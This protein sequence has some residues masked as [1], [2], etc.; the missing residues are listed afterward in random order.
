M[1][2]CWLL[3][4]RLSKLWYMLLRFHAKYITIVMLVVLNMLIKIS[5]WFFFASTTYGGTHCMRFHTRVTSTYSTGNI[6]QVRDC[7]CSSGAGMV[8][9]SPILIAV[10]TTAA[11]IPWRVMSALHTGVFIPVCFVL[12]STKHFIFHLHDFLWQQYLQNI[13]CSLFRCFERGVNDGA[14][15]IK[16]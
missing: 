4:T 9:P 10:P 6:L 14:G 8:F 16:G 15:A 5:T 13:C 12:K 2:T 3:F 7:N 1:I 11:Q